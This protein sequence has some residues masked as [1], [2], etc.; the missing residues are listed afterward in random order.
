LPAI[1]SPQARPLD[2]EPG[3]SRP[4]RVALTA[5]L[6]VSLPAVAHAQSTPAKPATPPQKAGDGEA[7][8]PDV[9]VSG[10]RPAAQSSIDRKT[11]QISHDLQSAS[12]SASDVLRNLPAVDVDA[13][14]NVSLRGDPNVQILI[15]GKPS[16]T[17][18]TIN[19][20]DTLE[21][22]P[23]NTIDHVEVITN[24]SAQFKPDGS[25]G[26]INIVTKKNRKPG[27]SGSVQAS[28]GS[29]GR[30][31]IGG[32]AT[33]HSGPL[34]V[35]GTLNLRRD[36]RWRPFS[37][38]RTEIDPVTGQT[39]GSSQDSLFRGAKLSR[40]VSASID[41]DL[42]AS[43]RLS[44]SGSYN[45][46]TGNPRITQH[47]VVTDASGVV[48]SDY[49]RTGGGDE[50]EN[51]SE[52]SAKY[53]H[54]FSQKGR[55]FTLDLRR[56]ES[57]EDETRR[58][59]NSYRLPA[60]LV[61][62]DQQHPHPDELEREVTAEYSQPLWGGKL[63][64]GY[65]LQRND[66]D[67]RNHG[68]LIDPATGVA[69]TDPSRT[70][71]FVYGQTVHAW[72]ATYNRPLSK[73]LTA[74][75][76]LRLEQAIISTNQVDLGLRSRSSYFRAYPTLHLQYDLSDDQ[77]LKFSYSHRVAR[78]E[79]ED[80]NPYPVFSDPLNLRAGNPNLKPQETHAVEAAYQY[81][82]HGLSLEATLFLRKSYN[83]F[84]E[85]SR[86]VTPTVLLTT[87]ENL[88]R[89]T[90]AGI[91]F[92]GN[93]K[94]SHTISYRLSGT[95]NRTTI[96]ASN[97]GFAGTRSAFG[98]TAKAGMDFQLARPDLVQVSANYNG[99]RLTPQGYRLPSFTANIGYRH[100]FASGLT[101]TISVADIFNSQH[102][103]NLID[104][105]ILR[106]SSTRRNTRRT[107][108]LALTMPFGG[109]RNAPDTPFD[110]GE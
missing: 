81:E 66:D 8:P 28:A 34:T 26:I 6:L 7:A 35:T 21:Q 15:D 22:F 106:E 62:I 64:A 50:K 49:D 48:V 87:K 100:R 60:G 3:L 89:S 93:G 18:S 84:T 79:A 72:Y 83:G 16:T 110:F 85:V 30:F 105:A 94:F 96:D 59:T 29:D 17:L 55:E 42:S 98:V 31:N 103:R 4:H 20:A 77:K 9:I 102:E 99:R 101:A 104:G 56:G 61:E 65:D 108:S 12:G 86:F 37:D 74:V 109:K 23:A 24:P 40:I 82:A 80:L 97:L 47:N 58:F 46:R 13:Q 19:R 43:D 57:I 2:G 78:P 76:G 10:Q 63:L 36:M 69:T 92:S 52:V 67:Y 53:R 27:A 14:G 90:A 32:N 75:L 45:Q 41:Y 39:T 44:A 5:I 95:L 33:W 71:R 73:S 54:S 11:Y 1:L 88:G 38:R 70:N 107:A 91:D 51:H 25:A 68:D